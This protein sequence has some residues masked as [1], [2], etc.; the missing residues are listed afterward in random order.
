MT[1]ARSHLYIAASLDGY[2]ADSK[3]SISWLDAFNGQEYGY[4]DYLESMP[5]MVL[6]RTTFDQAIGFVPDPYPGKRVIVLTH[7]PL[8]PHAPSNAQPYAGSLRG[9]AEDLAKEGVETFGLVGGGDV[10]RQ[11]IQEGLLD[12]IDLFII[13]VMLGSGTPLFP[14]PY[15]PMSLILH[16]TARYMNGVTYMRYEIPAQIADKGIP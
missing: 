7:R 14:A 16:E 1:R 5:V 9:L 6:G 10:N 12:L 11:F 3:G 4:A 2:I 8:P 15:P 13:P